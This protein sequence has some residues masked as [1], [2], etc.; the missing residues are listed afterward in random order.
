MT[1]EIQAAIQDIKSGKTENSVHSLEDTKNILILSEK[2]REA[3]QTAV[4]SSISC[5]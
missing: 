5:N 1:M 3:A 2:I 4:S